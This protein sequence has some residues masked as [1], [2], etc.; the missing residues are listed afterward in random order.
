MDQQILRCQLVLRA[1]GVALIGF[2]TFAVAA[3]LAD[4]V[5]PASLA[6]RL[7]MWHGGGTE[8][9]VMIG[10]I[11]VALGVGMVLASADPG[12]NRLAVDL[13]IG[14]HVAHLTAMF[15]MAVLMADH[16][17]H[18]AGDVPLGIIPAVALLAT[19]LPVRRR[20]DAHGTAP[21]ARG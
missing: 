13:V 2:F 5:D 3:A 17:A 15:T 16:H 18:L 7:L 14:I 9:V 4:A 1:T 11:N 19:W 6:G 21:A 8:Y 12:A 20:L 10:A